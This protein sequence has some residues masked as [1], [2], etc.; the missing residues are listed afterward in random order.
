MDR[1]Y[2]E[3]TKLPEGTTCADCV[4]VIRCT[5]IF[6]AKATNTS[7]EFHPCRYP[8]ASPS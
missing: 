2:D 8:E 1:Y 7:C 4:H 3:E 6:G 5:T